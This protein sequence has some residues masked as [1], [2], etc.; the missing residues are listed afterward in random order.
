MMMQ[1]NPQKLLNRVLDVLW[2]KYYAYN[3]TR[4]RA[5]VD[6]DWLESTIPIQNPLALKAL[7]N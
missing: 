6:P 5:F 7:L 4:L 1:S 3:L 2:D